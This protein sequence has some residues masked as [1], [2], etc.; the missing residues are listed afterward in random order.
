MSKFSQALDLHNSWPEQLRAS[1]ITALN[2]TLSI[3]ESITE[4]IAFHREKLYR[5]GAKFAVDI[6]IKEGVSNTNHVKS[7]RAYLVESMFGEFREPLIELEMH[8]YNND[9]EEAVK[10]LQQIKQTMYDY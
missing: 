2:K 4:P 5:L 1:K 8:L 3:E 6:W 7:A 10:C 9:I